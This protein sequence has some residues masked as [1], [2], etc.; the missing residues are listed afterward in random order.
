MCRFFNSYEE[1]LCVYVFMNVYKLAKYVR[2]C[3][4]FW[5]IYTANKNFTRPPVATVA[6]NSKSALRKIIFAIISNTGTQAR[7]GEAIISNF[8]LDYFSYVFSNF[9]HH[10]IKETQARK[11]RRLFSTLLKISHSVKP[12]LQF[13]SHS[14]MRV[15]F[16][17]K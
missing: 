7:T 11:E 17:M 14:G 5:K 16:C 6:T 8:A 2:N 13:N 4:V 9:A 12:L 3:V 10:P 1:S 15:L